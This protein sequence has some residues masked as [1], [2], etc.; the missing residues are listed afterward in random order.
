V[1]S[2]KVIT[3]SVPLPL[4]TPASHQIGALMKSTFCL[5][6][7][8]FLY[9]SILAECCRAVERPPNVVLIL[10]DDMGWQDPTCFGGKAVPTP[11]IDAL[12]ASGLKMT[13]FYSSS[14]VCS[15]TRASILTGRYPLRFDI[16]THF[17]DDET[18]LP[19]GVTTLPALL[20]QNGYQT[21]HIG[22]WHLGGLHLS[23]AKSRATS[24]PGPREHGF[25]HYLCQNEEPPLRGQMGKERRLYTD[26]GTCLLRDDMPVPEADPYFHMHLTDIIGAESLRLVT[27]F[28]A[29][30]RP[31]FLNIWHLVPHLPY[32]PGSEPHWSNTYA[33]GISDDQHR[34][35][36]MMAHMDAT[37]G[38]LIKKL[39]ELG[40]REQ[41]LIVF[42]SDNGG[43][44][45]GDIGPLK[46]GKTDL[47]EG[48]IRV[49]FIASWPGHIPAG[50][51]SEQIGSTID[52]LPTV[53][54]AAGITL[55]AE[56][57][58]DGVNLLPHWESG[59]DISR[60]GPL[61]WQLDLYPRLQ[62]Q[63]PKPEP[64]ATEVAMDGK[65]KLLSRDGQPLELFDLETDLEEQNHVLDD[66][67]EM[68]DRLTNAVRD[69]LSAP[70]DRRGH[71]KK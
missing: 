3:L 59:K 51:T 12:A 68:R 25:D 19:L 60:G 2:G 55:S 39:E 1:K 36:S 67:P 38:N 41:T 26:G 33:P 44:F 20:K 70:R 28:H 46:G 62:R 34:F 13:R 63:Y 61:F 16:R 48:G 43:V 57:Y 47:H 66:H 9:S 30:G 17:S 15:P 35:R 64:Y 29:D 11:H 8:V 6:F 69:F 54:T 21:A 58:L 4:E 45:E 7:A 18:H 23:H 50:G 32:E 53:C 52:L 14:A 5:G 31:F 42:T 22:K 10:A 56:A 40:I 71:P 37:I 65:W 24:I 49:S 27:Q